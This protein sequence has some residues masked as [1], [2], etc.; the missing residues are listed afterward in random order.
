[1]NE[2]VGPSVRV[3]PQDHVK[4]EAGVAITLV[5]Y[6]DC[7]GPYCGEAYVIVEALRRALGDDLRFVFRN[8]PLVEVHPHAQAAAELAE[9][10]ALQD[11][12]WQMHDTLYRNQRDLSE[13]ALQRYAH[14]VDLDTTRLGVDLAS[15]APRQRVDTDFEGA[16]RSGAK[17]TPTFFVNGQRYDGSWQF[18]PLRDYLRSLLSS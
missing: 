10:V 5:E 1:M 9:A 7:R 11:R 15:G 3:G 2:H 18:D 17:G 14:D 16:T 8:L 6:G 4:G 13:A 12:F